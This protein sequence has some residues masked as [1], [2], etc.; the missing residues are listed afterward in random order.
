MRLPRFSFRLTVRRLMVAVA[1]VAV[2]IGIVTE[3]DRRRERYTRLARQHSV[4]R[5]E[6]HKFLVVVPPSGSLEFFGDRRAIAE[7]VGYHGRLKAKYEEA[8]RHPWLPVEPDPPE[9]K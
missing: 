6:L 5:D 8:A 9:P 3:L 4:V 7:L 2:V 1:I